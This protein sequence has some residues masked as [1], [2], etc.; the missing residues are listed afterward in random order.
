MNHA[1]F[2]EGEREGRGGEG[3]LGGRTGRE[4]G[5]E[6]GREDWGTMVGGGGWG[7]EGGGPPRRDIRMNLVDHSHESHAPFA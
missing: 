2:M 3:G 5:R 4:G 1:G 7:E 6:G